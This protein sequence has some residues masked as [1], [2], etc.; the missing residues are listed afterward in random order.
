MLGKFQSDDVA[1]SD[2]AVVPTIK[3]GYGLFTPSR[4]L[5]AGTLAKQDEAVKMAVGR[6]APKLE[7]MLAMKLL[8]L[9]E[10]QASSYLSV[11]L[12]LLAAGETK[13]LLLQR[14]TRQASGKAAKS[15]LADAVERRS[16]PVEFSKG[17]QL[18]YQVLNFGEAPVYTMLL[19]FDARDRMLAFFPP[20]DGQSYSVELIQAAL[21]LLPGKSASLPTQN[22][23][24]IDDSQGRVE[25][26]LVCSTR[27]LT[28]SWQV[29]ISMANT[30]SNQ[31]VNLGSSALPLVRALLDD[32][33][34]GEDADNASDSYTL[35][36]VN[37]A[38]VGC[39]YSI[40]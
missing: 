4:D 7:T 15:R 12:N 18:C 20:S 37:W 14:E 35:N 1:A 24:V 25:T 5:V 33:S 26:Y 11:R 28:N 2:M 9:S 29:L 17:A 19:G 30:A 22:T 27:P 36:T 39:H 38:T 31:R 13:K 6:L 40:V 10:N 32:L 8:R 3:Q 34:A 16:R 23:W 21:T